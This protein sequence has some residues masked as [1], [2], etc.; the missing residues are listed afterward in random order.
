[1]TILRNVVIDM[2]RARSV[3]PRLHPAPDTAPEPADPHD[4]FE[5]VTQRMVLIDG[6]AAVSDAHRDVV[7]N[8]VVRDRPHRD[9]AAE[10]GLPLGTVRS[11]VFH[12]L[13]GL[14]RELAAQ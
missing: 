13:R 4:A 2:V 14:R 10:F 5:R 8:V 6:L 3:R 1:A 11:R 9:V 12:A 7:L